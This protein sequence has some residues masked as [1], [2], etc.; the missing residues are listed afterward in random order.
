M[1]KNRLETS[2]ENKV[3]G[4]DAPISEVEKRKAKAK[5]LGAVHAIKVNKKGGE[6]FYAFLSKP[7]RETIELVMGR[8]TAGAGGFGELRMIEAGE[9]TLRNGRIKEVSDERI[10]EDED[11]LISASFVAYKT[12][13]IRL[14]ELEE[15]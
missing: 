2:I 15:L 5:A 13:N 4:Q 10:L 14:G 9:I 8:L 12:I 11:L 6:D 1:K 3:N 7:S